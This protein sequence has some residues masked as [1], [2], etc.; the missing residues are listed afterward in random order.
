MKQ[1]GFSGMRNG[2]G[3]EAV[4]DEEQTFCL[5]FRTMGKDLENNHGGHKSLPDPL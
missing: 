5:A 2:G 4:G 3:H 1:M